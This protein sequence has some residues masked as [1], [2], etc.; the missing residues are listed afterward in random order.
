MS[1]AGRQQHWQGVYT[2]N[3]AD[4][5]SWHQEHPTV[6]LDLVRASD[7]GPEGRLIDVGGGA[8]TLVDHLLDLGYRAITVLDIAGSALAAAR[9]RLGERASLVEWVEADV[10]T[11]Q[12]STRYDL[13][14]DRA[15]FH[16]LTEAADRAGYKIALGAA[17]RTG[18]AAII[19][20]F[21][22]D[23]PERCSGL[24]VVRYSPESL[25][26]ELG[27]GYRLE[28]VEHED[29]HTPAGRTQHFVYCRFRRVP[30]P[31]S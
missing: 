4:E 22:P 27:P 31:A 29:H 11:S 28:Q 16:F 25:T 14:H 10:T 7:V 6:S 26:A 17:L 2:R 3:A 13:W 12:P 1:Q 5:V 23:G 18:G 30:P 24:P 8:S 19:A 15:V 20:T 9:R 21:A